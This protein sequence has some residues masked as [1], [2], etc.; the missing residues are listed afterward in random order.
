M[1]RAPLVF[2]KLGGALLTH[3]DQSA[4]PRSAELRRLVGEIAPAWR[5]RSIRL[6][7]GHGSGSFAHVAAQ[8]SGFWIQSGCGAQHQMGARRVQQIDRARIGVQRPG[9]GPSNGVEDRAQVGHRVDG[10]EDLPHGFNLAHALFEEL[11]LG[12]N[13]LLVHV[14]D[15]VRLRRTRALS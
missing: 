13:G 14:T 10:P 7:L 11:T 3:K 2:L 6:V 15:H 12:N 5:E 8:R 1:N 9:G 4:S